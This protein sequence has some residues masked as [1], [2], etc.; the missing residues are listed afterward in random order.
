MR[1]SQYETKI[2]AGQRVDHFETVRLRKDGT[3]FH[4]SL[5]VFP[6]LDSTREIVG[7]CAIT[8]DIT[9]RKRAEGKLKQLT[10]AMEASIDGIAILNEDQKYVYLNKAHTRIYGYDTAEEL[11]G[12]SWH[13]LYNADELQR[14]DNDIMSEFSQKGQWQGEATGKKKDGSAFFQDISL[15]A[16]G[17]GGMICIVRDITERKRAEEEILREKRQTENPFRQ[18]PLRYGPRRSKKVIL[19]ISIESFSNSLAMSSMIF[20]TAKT[21]FRKAYPDVEYRQMVIST[22]RKDFRRCQTRWTYTEGFTVYV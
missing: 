6:I 8:R 11:I 3:P 15:T 5:G 4:V 2:G 18:C 22:W 1:W 19:P 21:W 7:I 12:Q 20:L 17:K 10:A 14:F 9:E 16:L 13:I